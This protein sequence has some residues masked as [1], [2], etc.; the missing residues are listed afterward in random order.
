[1]IAFNKLWLRAAIC[2]ST[3][4]LIGW[5]F[6]YGQDIPK[7]INDWQ[8]YQERQLAD[9]QDCENYRRTGVSKYW[10][11]D[12]LGA[13]LAG[14]FCKD[15]TKEPPPLPSSQQMILDRLQGVGELLLVIWGLFAGLQWLIRGALS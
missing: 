3:V 15:A 5:Y 8:R 12:K 4:V 7:E 13:E 11:T 10:S 14:I 2:T 1:V 9:Y 6:V